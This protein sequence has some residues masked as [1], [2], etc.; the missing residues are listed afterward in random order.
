MN[1][2]QPERLKILI[3]RIAS[4][5]FL[6]FAYYFFIKLTG[7]KIPCLSYVIFKI[8]CPGCGLTRM[9]VALIEGNIQLAF[10]QNALM[11][12]LIPVF[13]IWSSYNGYVFLFDK[14]HKFKTLNKIVILIVFLSAVVFTVLRN[15][16][17]FEFLAPIP[18]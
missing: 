14:E 5:L 13:L 9:C 11:F 3:I 18:W 7:L 16:Q 10:R 4:Y 2:I 17:Q 8:H 12:C 6:G 1:K 15:L